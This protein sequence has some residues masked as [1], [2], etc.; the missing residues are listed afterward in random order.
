MTAPD[1]RTADED[2]D[3]SGFMRAWVA[4]ARGSTRRSDS[5][6]FSGVS[7]P[8]PSQLVTASPRD[9]APVDPQAAA[10]LRQTIE[11]SVMQQSGS[12]DAAHVRSVAQRASHNGAE[13]TTPDAGTSPARTRAKQRRT[14]AEQSPVS[15]AL[16][17]PQQR[18]SLR[19]TPARRA[20]SAAV[21]QARDGATEQVNGS[22]LH[23][24]YTPF[25]PPV[26]PQPA[27][28][29]PLVFLHGVGFGIFPYLGFVRRLLN[30]FAGA[31]HSCRPN[32]PLTGTVHASHVATH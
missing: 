1:Q 31:H 11:G 12:L 7:L 4:A 10:A 24:Q 27:Q 5:R 6:L 17:Q 26:E 20:H 21:Q 16:A 8:S 9:A 28:Q 13:H 23:S 14:C 22:S 19:S 3:G 25:A 30:A 15:P 29:T 2:T 32:A 18:Y